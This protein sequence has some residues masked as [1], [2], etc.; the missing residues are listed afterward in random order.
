M[1]T[2][3]LAQTSATGQLG[4]ALVVT[5]N[6]I[7]KSA[8]AV[9]PAQPFTQGSLEGNIEGFVQVTTGEGGVGVD[10]EVFLSNLPKEGAP[11]LFHIHVDPVDET[12]NCTNT[13]AHLDPYI[14]GEAPPCDPGRPQACQIGDLSG[15]Y[16]AITSDPYTAQFHDDFLSMVEGPGSYF[17]NRSLVIH[18]SNATRITCAN[19][20]IISGGVNRSY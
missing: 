9:L 11:F 8:V 13:L 5:N 6:P 14:R 12:G 2:G 10:F 17:L 7:G 16:G 3:A 4:D 18:Y 1:S 20:E 15:K 19:F